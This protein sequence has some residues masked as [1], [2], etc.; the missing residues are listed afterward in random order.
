M[1][2]GPQQFRSVCVVVSREDSR[3]LDAYVQRVGFLHA[4]RL[5]GMS[6]GV[7]RA[8]MDQGRMLASTRDR[9]FAALDRVEAI[10]S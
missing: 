4:P 7:V 6:D 9:L 5:L 10:A 8:G 2:R 3:R 1:P